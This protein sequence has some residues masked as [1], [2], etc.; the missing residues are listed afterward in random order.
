LRGGPPLILA[1]NHPA[2]IDALLILTRH[3]N[4]V[5]VMKSS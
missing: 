2:L 4:L 1:P 5:C 3:P